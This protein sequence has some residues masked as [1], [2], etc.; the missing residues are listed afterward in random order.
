MAK[1]RATQVDATASIAVLDRS[2]EPRIVN[3]VEP[4]TCRICSS[5]DRADYENVRRVEG[6]FTCQK[7]GRLAV[8]VILRDTRC[9]K[10]GQRRCDREPVYAT[11][12]G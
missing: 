12:L 1:S 10:C 9:L 4:S 2:S 5:Q 7:T 8:A 3:N 11:E 6:D